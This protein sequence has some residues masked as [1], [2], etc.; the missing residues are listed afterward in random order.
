VL[1]L[2]SVSVFEQ[3]IEMSA[4]WEIGEFFGTVRAEE[5]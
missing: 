1:R 3:S 4:V 2:L 5:G